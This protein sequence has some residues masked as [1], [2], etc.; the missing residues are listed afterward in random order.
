MVTTRFTDKNGHEV[1][2]STVTVDEVILARKHAVYVSATLTAD[3]GT[4]YDEYEIA[5][6]VGF[7]PQSSFV[8]EA[9]S[10]FFYDYWPTK[11]EDDGVR[12]LEK[13]LNKHAIRL[14]KE[15][16]VLW[17]ADVLRRNQ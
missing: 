17:R 12:M 7:V 8:V 4:G 9:W 2:L 11:S 1:V 14:L 13:H 5:F 10:V 6:A 16:N 3:L 15:A